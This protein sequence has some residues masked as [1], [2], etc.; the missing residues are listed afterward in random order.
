LKCIDRFQKYREDD[1]D[2]IILKVRNGTIKP[3]KY[4]HL[5]KVDDDKKMKGCEFFNEKSSKSK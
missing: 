2:Q 3:G 1:F 5:V 4:A